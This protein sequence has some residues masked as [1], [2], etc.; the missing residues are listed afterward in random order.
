MRPPHSV[1]ELAAL[2]EMPWEW[3]VYCLGD[4][5]ATGSVAIHRT[6]GPADVASDVAL[7]QWVLAGLGRL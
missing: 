1:A 3:P 5:A 2:L 7:M 4:L 6:V